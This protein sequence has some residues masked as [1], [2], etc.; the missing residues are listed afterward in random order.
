MLVDAALTLG[1]A[2]LHAANRG[3]A[4]PIPR[5]RHRAGYDHA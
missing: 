2:A 5:R 1:F 4:N 3:W